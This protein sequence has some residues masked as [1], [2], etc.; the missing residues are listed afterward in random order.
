MK[1]KSSFI[2]S[3]SYAFEGIWTA[4]KGRNFN[5][6]VVLGIVAVL[7]AFLLKFS[8]SEWVILLLTIDLVITAELLNTSIEAV[9]DLVSPE[10][11]EKAKIAKDV[12][13]AGVL[14]ASCF[15]VLV[16]ILLFLPKIFH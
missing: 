13:V 5:I 16:A 3:F 12:S 10:I 4:L 8:P 15:A 11:R 7:M 6:I 1:S 14:I 9:V 2:Q